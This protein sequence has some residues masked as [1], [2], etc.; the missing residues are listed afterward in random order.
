[1]RSWAAGLSGS[2]REVGLLLT[3]GIP[4]ILLSAILG[5]F[6]DGGGSNTEQRGQAPCGRADMAVL[7]HTWAIESMMRVCYA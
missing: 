5:R 2:S 6:A 4:L 7:G 1:M 3:L